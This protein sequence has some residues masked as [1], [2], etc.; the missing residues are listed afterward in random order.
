MS[1]RVFPPIAYLHVRH[2]RVL[3]AVRLARHRFRRAEVEASRPRLPD[4]PAAGDGAAI[5]SRGG[6]QR[7]SLCL[8]RCRG[9]NGGRRRRCG[10]QLGR[11]ERWRCG[12]S[13]C[14]QK[15]R[16]RWPR[17]DPSRL[18]TP[19]GA[20][21]RAFPPYRRRPCWQVKAM[22]LADDAVLRYAE[23]AADLGGRQTFVPKRAQSD[24]SLFGPFHLRSPFLL[25]G[26]RSVL[27]SWQ[28]PT[29][30]TVLP[31]ATVGK[32]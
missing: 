4:G 8:R 15:R 6:R 21:W 9:V 28:R 23:P 18:R 26:S 30:S 22:R 29:S 3:F 20:S 10:R 2:L 17:C 16:E 13:A 31:N 1:D 7:E 14:A 24:D 5:G 25:C 32:G 11:D 12:H 27:A 19:R